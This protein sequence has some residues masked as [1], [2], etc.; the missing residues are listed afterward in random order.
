M[1]H[2]ERDLEDFLSAYIEAAL[3]ST[4]D[5]SDES[6]GNPLD[7]NYS[8]ADIEPDT[9]EQMRAECNAFLA[10]GAAELIDAEPNPPRGRDGS[11]RWEMAG[12]DFWLTRCGH[13]AG[14]WDGDWPENGDALTELSE[15]AEERWLY[16]G[17]DGKIY[18]G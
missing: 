3:W 8:R 17:D 12:H 11:N 10:G 16:L 13:G 6:G 5:E 2:S 4:N 18:Q 14:F 7:D 15:K 1:P 9:L